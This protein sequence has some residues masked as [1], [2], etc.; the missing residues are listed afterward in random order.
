[1]IGRSKSIESATWALAGSAMVISMLGMGAPS[2]TVIAAVPGN[3]G[4]KT[5][6]ELE[7]RLNA[8]VV[9]GDVATF[10]KLFADDFTHT[11][12]DGRFRTRAEWMKGRVQGKTNYVSF[13]VDDLQIRIFSETAVVTGLSKPS[14]R[15]QDGSLANGQFRFLR[16]WAK[17]DGR[18]QAVAFQATRISDE[19]E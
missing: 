2:S 14:W 3:A 19:K 7:D 9:Q 15:E 18:W 11:S 10:D 16:V 8:A 6:R 1:M 12:R 13:D 4:E 5:V 17:R